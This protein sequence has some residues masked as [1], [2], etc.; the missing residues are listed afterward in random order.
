MGTNHRGEVENDLIVRMS[1]SSGQVTVME[2]QK[3]VQGMQ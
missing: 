2:K 3:G 1:A